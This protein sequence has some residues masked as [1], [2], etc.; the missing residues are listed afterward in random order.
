MSVSSKH[1]FLGCSYLL[2]HPENL[3][4]C[5]GSDPSWYFEKSVI[6]YQHLPT[7]WQLWAVWPSAQTGLPNRV[8]HIKIPSNH[9]A[10]CV[11]R[12][13]EWDFLVKNDY[14]CEKQMEKLIIVPEDR[15]PHSLC[16]ARMRSLM[17]QPA[18][19]M[20][21]EYV[22]QKSKDWIELKELIKALP[23]S[24]PS[25]FQT[26]L[27]GRWLTIFIFKKNQ[28][29]IILLRLHWKRELLE[30]LQVQKGIFM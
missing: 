21:L 12:A 22:V 3:K 13:S 2:L 11:L 5:G 7:T 4:S 20:E 18:V 27:Q 24:S 17:E 28:E 15:I 10:V 25:S 19:S 30:N 9:L 16:Y 1:T 29:G 6:G 14:V 23:F 8:N 26:F